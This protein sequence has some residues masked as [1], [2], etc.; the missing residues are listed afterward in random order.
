MCPCTLVFPFVIKL[1]SFHILHM[2]F[3][4]L[5]LIG[6][7][8]HRDMKVEMSW[9]PLRMACGSPGTLNGNGLAAEPKIK[10]HPLSNYMTASRVGGRSCTIPSW[11]LI[12]HSFSYWILL[13]KA[14]LLKLT[15][16]ST[17]LQWER[18]KR[19]MCQ[20]QARRKTVEWFAKHTYWR[21]YQRDYITPYLSPS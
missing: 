12:S 18:G 9:I 5:S 1:C 11:C 19:L 6:R 3:S 15:T 20:L 8:C 2:F 14:G 4:H 16:P 21:M 13:F 7:W 10:V 17:S